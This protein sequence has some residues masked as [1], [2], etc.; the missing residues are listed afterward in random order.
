MI[1]I[2]VIEREEAC[3]EKR[4]DGEKKGEWGGRKKKG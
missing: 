4:R 2:M 1:H 3:R